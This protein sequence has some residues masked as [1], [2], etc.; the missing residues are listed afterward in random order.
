ML[1]TVIEHA[2]EKIGN[3]WEAGQNR[4]L[5]FTVK[6]VRQGRLIRDIGGPLR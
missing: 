1:L 6:L 5:T 2:L 3:K 4:S